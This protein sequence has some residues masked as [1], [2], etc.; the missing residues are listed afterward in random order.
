MHGKVPGLYL[1]LPIA[2]PMTAKDEARLTE[3]GEK[4]SCI[5]LFQDSHSHYL[6]GTFQSLCEVRRGE[7]LPHYVETET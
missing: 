3:K 7:V 6:S 1:L 4:Y 5:Y 2:S